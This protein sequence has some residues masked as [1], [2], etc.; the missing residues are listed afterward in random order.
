MSR[1]SG[2]RG[3]WAPNK[4]PYLTMAPDVYVAL[5]GETSII[6][7]GECKQPINFNDY[8]TG[9]S[10]EA[11]VDSPP[12]S[13]TITLTIPDNDVNTFYVDG[14]F[15]MIPMM[16]VEIYSKGYYL[17]G[18]FPQYYRIFWGVVSSVTKDWSGG[19]T[20][21]QVQCK[22]ILR[23][24]EVT[25]V[26]I[27]PA[28]LESFGS[29]AGGYQLW[30][31]QFAG[32]NPYSTII[33]LAKEAM[34][35]FSL[36]TGSFTSFLPEKGPESGVI[37]SYAKDI[38]TYWQYKFSN[39]WNSL[40]LF[41]ASGQSYQFTGGG[42]TVSPVQLSEAIFQNEAKLQNQNQESELFT[43]HPEEQA[44]FKKELQKAGDVE[45]FQNEIQTKLSVAQQARDQI[46]Y[47][48][49]CD[50]CGDI[51]FKPPFYNLNVI[52][53]KPVSWIN[54]F[55]IIDDSITDTEQEVYTH[56]TASGNAFGGVMDWG[57]NDEITTPRTGVFDFHLLRRY[58]FRKIDYPTEWAGDPRK[59]F[60]H[61]MDYLDKTNAKRQNGTI[62]IPLRPELRL[63]FPV[64][65]PYYDSFFYVTG[66]SHQFSV[67]GQA[68]TTLTLI[69]RRQ[70]FIA[71]NNIGQITFGQ[72]GQ[73]PVMIT[74]FSTAPGAKKKVPGLEPTYAI[75][76]PDNAGASSGLS[77]TSGNQITAG[78]PVS[79]RDPKTG[80]LLG[81]PNVVMVFRSQLNSD[82]LQK[83]IQSFGS[84]QSAPN[85]NQQKQSPN[86]NPTAGTKN[87]YNTIQLDILKHLQDDQK[88]QLL[89][90]L[91]AHRYES[92][93]TNAGAYDYAHDQ[94][95][96]LIDIGVV[97]T[98]S[99]TWGTGTQDPNMPNP[100]LQILG[101]VSTEN[102]QQIQAQ[103]AA[104]IAQN[105]KDATAAVQ[106]AQLVVTAKNTA[107]T[108]LQKQKNQAAASNS[109]TNTGNTTNTTNSGTSSTATNT[110]ASSTSDAVTAAQAEVVTATA[111]LTEA[112][113]K[114]AEIK[115]GYGNLRVLPSLNIIIRPVSD[116]FGFEV[117]GHY[118]YGRG[119]YIDQ[120]QVKLFLGAN[121][122][123]KGQ[124]VN[125]LNI[126]F[127]AT[128]GIIS[129]ATPVQPGSGQVINFAAQFEQ[130]QPEDWVT[131]ASFQGT[132]SPTGQVSQIQFTGQATYTS[133]MQENKATGVW[134]E[135]DQLR[136]AT[137][138]GELS[139]QVSIAGLDNATPNCACGLD[140]AEWLSILPQSLIQTV[141]QGGS[142]LAPIGQSVMTDPNSLVDGQ[143]NI[144]GAGGV[145]A[146]PRAG[147]ET[148]NPIGAIIGTATPSDFFTQLGL[149]LAQ[150]FDKQYQQGNAQLELQDTGQSLGVV[151]QLFNADE[152]TNVLG[153]PQNPLF[154]PAS[155][156]DPNA[157]AKL[158]GQVNFN[159][160]QSTNALANFK[161]AYDNGSSQINQSLA[162]A[163][164]G[165]PQFS[166][167]TS[168][169]SSTTTV[170]TP[171]VP[172]P[173]P[174]STVVITQPVPQVQPIT[175]Q[176]IPNVRG[177]I[178]NPSLNSILLAQQG[179]A[180]PT[181]FTAGTAP[182]TIKQGV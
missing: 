76:F 17:I 21:I 127:A 169:P 83:I 124:T 72:P 102:F 103:T 31:N 122:E 166:A 29:S 90:R 163:S 180:Q 117:I 150:Q 110:E 41:G 64:W 164:P 51:V 2:F 109:T 33:Q 65:V 60:F 112:Q 116:E 30:Q 28:F 178:L 39:I 27:N 14:Q 96:T 23:W 100:I 179:A 15:I 75:S 1:V 34:G 61:C 133:S 171:Q 63:G 3:T 7:C 4:R 159:F 82:N 174:A 129:D 49:F 173:P 37:G 101:G 38:M 8:V 161:T 45:F 152:Q 11:S 20:T 162:Q 92:G 182:G 69:A 153:D 126:Q 46:A 144:Q 151:S 47:E 145:F 73:K 52:P 175:V 12:G 139:P 55:E 44:T 91:R 50:P 172:V 132:G 134:I 35:D 170:S 143:G 9:V 128:A 130:M 59:L 43:I 67:G 77:Q 181:S 74:N 104:Q 158:Q 138:L 97:P 13:A 147:F 68:T 137:T 131:G 19:S 16:E 89:Q 24:W 148:T 87:Q 118:R 120:G 94:T 88:G 157:I 93:M 98:T 81:Y 142:Q 107:L 149:Y 78:Q 146:A 56:V 125:Q 155:L 54:D 71:P 86:A 99:I 42:G 25:N 6:A 167:T 140:R 95:R 22:D 36:N 123:A 57:L 177:A 113:R 106:A 105:I 32:L 85:Q 18:G 160:G 168:P 156:G 119:A 108:A 114:L 80:Q 40:V 53:N 84:A 141:L 135:A 26:T 10:T 115:A 48:F 79:I 154:G 66:I 136:K 5:Q 176:P 111:A 62:T 58:G 121:G 70:K 165:S